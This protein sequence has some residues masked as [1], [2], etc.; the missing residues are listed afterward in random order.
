MAGTFTRPNTG[1]TLTAVAIDGWLDELEELGTVRKAGTLIGTRSKLNFIEGSNITLTIADD[2]VNDEIDIT[3]G[4]T[5]AAGVGGGHAL[6][7]AASNAN[8]TVKAR[9][10]YVCDGV[11]DDVQIQAALDASVN[12]ILTPGDFA[13]AAPV[14]LKTHG[15]YLI[16]SGL[17]TQPDITRGALGTRLSP[18]AGAG[19]NSVNVNEGLLIAAN[20]QRDVVGTPRTGDF[21]PRVGCM[22]ANLTVDGVNTNGAGATALHGIVFSCQ[23]GMIQ[24]VIARR[25]TGDGIRLEGKTGDQLYETQLFN[26][27]ARN[28]GGWG[29]NAAQNAGDAHVLHCTIKECTSGAIKPGAAWQIEDLHAYGNAG[30]GIRIESRGVRVLNGK[31]ETNGK[32]IYITGAATTFQIVGVG[33]QNNCQDATNTNWIDLHISD[34]NKG[35]VT[36]CLFDSVP[37]FGS[38]HSY[39]NIKIDNTGDRVGI[40]GNFFDGET[41]L[42]NTPTYNPAID[43]GASSDSIRIESNSGF[44]TRNSGSTAI[45]AAAGGVTISHG[46]GTH[47]GTAETVRVGI[48]PDKVNAMARGTTPVVVTRSNYTATTFTVRLWD[49][50]GA[51]ITS[52]AYDID[53]DAEK[54]NW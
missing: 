6:L 22:I 8:A 3:V 24:N 20:T 34:A 15:Q 39:Y 47:S 16:G 9:A 12:V 38:N 52:G 23:L 10:D 37:A 50:A 51:E 32:G 26:I 4:A 45:T 49:M 27:Q 30:P 29:I 5:G 40:V 7:V 25:C 42:N 44:R 2:A 1:D 31:L 54:L 53:W 41:R 36:G 18:S 46:L 19:F 13:L 43:V 35:I 17:A 14:Y 48:I 28:C 21:T 33:F 11:A